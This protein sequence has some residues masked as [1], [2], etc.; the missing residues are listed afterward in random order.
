MEKDR[1]GRSILFLWTHVRDK[2]NV[3]EGFIINPYPCRTTPQEMIW[4]IGGGNDVHIA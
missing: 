2:F 4:L 3:F 1:E